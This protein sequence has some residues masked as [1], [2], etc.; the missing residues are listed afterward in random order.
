MDLD[1]IYFIRLEAYLCI[2]LLWLCTKRLKIRPVAQLSLNAELTPWHLWNTLSFTSTHRRFWNSRTPLLRGSLASSRTYASCQ[3]VFPLQTSVL[4]F[5]PSAFVMR[6]GEVIS[7]T[8]PSNLNVDSFL[9]SFWL[10]S[11]I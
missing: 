9:N 6:F 5:L 8:I 1:S 10:L 3:A 7:V 2:D 11:S 4:V